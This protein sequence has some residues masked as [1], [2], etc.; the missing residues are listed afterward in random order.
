MVI[1]ASSKKWKNSFHSQLPP[2]IQN[3]RQISAFTTYI[4]VRPLTGRPF[5][6]ENER[7]VTAVT[8]SSRG[9]CHRQPQTTSYINNNPPTRHIDRFR[10]F[11]ACWNDRDRRRGR[12]FRRSRIITHSI[13]FLRSKQYRVWF[14]ATIS[15]IVFHFAI[16][17][18]TIHYTPYTRIDDYTLRYLHHR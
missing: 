11:G 6:L 2:L 14:L 10:R 16:S 17:L 5:V 12:T 8:R 4:Y 3:S 18:R 13:R 9:V 7:A 1:V 15:I